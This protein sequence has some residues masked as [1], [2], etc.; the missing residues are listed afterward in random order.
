MAK[1]K[2]F[3]EYVKGDEVDLDLKEPHIIDGRYEFNEIHDQLFDH[4]FSDILW[5]DILD[6]DGKSIAQWD[7]GVSYR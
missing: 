6:E 3:V 2:V 4:G 5:I 7:N 1:V